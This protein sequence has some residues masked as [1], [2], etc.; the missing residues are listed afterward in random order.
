MKGGGAGGRGLGGEVGGV[1]KDG[2][3]LELLQQKVKVQLGLGGRSFLGRRGF[4]DDLFYQ[5]IRNID[6]EKNILARAAN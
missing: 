1:L 2:G 6:Y 4:G 3:G 5:P